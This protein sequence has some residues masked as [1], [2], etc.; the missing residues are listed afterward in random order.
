M[1]VTVNQL[2]PL[3]VTV[4]FESLPTHDEDEPVMFISETLDTGIPEVIKE[5]LNTGL[6]VE[7]ENACEAKSVAEGLR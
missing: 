5:A 1:K 3:I 4:A 2:S 7:F 6:E